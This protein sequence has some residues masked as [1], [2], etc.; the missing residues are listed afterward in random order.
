[1]VGL[2]YALCA[3]RTAAA[4]GRLIGRLLLVLCLGFVGVRLDGPTVVLLVCSFMV[5]YPTTG[6]RSW[7]R[8]IN[9]PVR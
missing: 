6:L 9:P 2:V 7:L 5:I 1:M 3:E 8:S 4:I